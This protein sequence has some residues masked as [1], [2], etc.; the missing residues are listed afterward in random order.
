MLGCLKQ[1]ALTNFVCELILLRAL[2]C[3]ELI[4]YY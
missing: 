3:I 4:C 2:L 1:R